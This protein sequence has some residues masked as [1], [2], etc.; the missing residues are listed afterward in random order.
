MAG[1]SGSVA[2][3]RRW[4]IALAGTALQ[5]CLGTVY[6]WSFFQNP[7]KEAFGWSDSLT[8][9]AFS[10]TIGSVGLA[11]AAG[12]SLLPR[13]GPARLAMA[14]GCLFGL[15]YLLGAVALHQ[16][17]APLLFLTYGV[18]GGAGLGLGYV[19]PVATVAR[20][21]PDR[22]GLATGLV[23]MGFGLGALA[24]SK[25]FAPL[26]MDWFSR[27][28]DLQRQAATVLEGG[29]EVVRHVLRR[30][31][32]LQGVLA[33]L[34]AALGALFLLLTIPLGYCL[35]NP[36]PGWQPGV[37]AGGPGGGRAAQDGDGPSLRRC[38]LSGRFAGLWVVFFCNITAGI[39]VIGF[40][41]PLFQDLWRRSDP[42]LDPALTARWGAT[43]IGVTALFNGLGR[44]FWA[45]L[46]DRIGRART[47]TLMLGSQAAVFLALGWTRSPWV[48]AVLL[49]YVLLCY[50]GG[51]GMMP[52]FV[53]D[54]FGPRR[55]AAVY[56]AMLTA[57]SAGGVAGPQLVAVIKDRA[58]P[59]AGRLAF[60]A[61]AALVAAGFLISLRTRDDRLAEPVP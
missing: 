54:V 3:S 7:L 29:R 37:P 36:P 18:V 61:G 45:G 13:V 58:G 41:S 17:S 2:R 8:A 57:W 30:P 28:A 43:L 10:L 4:L 35:R 44:F 31:E 16:R 24:M 15:G 34:F 39:A 32:A 51:F 27:G 5:V 12:G 38:V 14:G 59:D 33:R 1:D 11:A 23:V 21:F 6:A 48:F 52:S 20:W 19:T 40:Q 53:L 50:G 60:W 9:W 49:C 55:M 47:F 25:V 46:S 22:K 42:S 56:G 26:L